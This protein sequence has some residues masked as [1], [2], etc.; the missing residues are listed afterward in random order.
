MT[1]LV[2]ILSCLAICSALMAIFTGLYKIGVE[3]ERAQAS[4]NN[5]MC[6]QLGTKETE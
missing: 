6:T 4:T 1:T 3:A 2:V 5:A